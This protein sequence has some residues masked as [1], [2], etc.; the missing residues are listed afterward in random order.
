[1]AELNNDEESVSL[2]FNILYDSKHKLHHIYLSENIESD[3][4]KYF[5]L[6][7]FFNTASSTTSVE[8]HLNSGG[9]SLVVG[10]QLYWAIRT[11]KAKVH[12]IVEHDCASMGA[13]LALA[14]DTVE[15]RPGTHLMFHNYSS[16]LPRTKGKE[17][18]TTI[19]NISKSYENLLIHSCVPFLS[20]D[21]LRLILNDVDIYVYAGDDFDIRLKR[22]YRA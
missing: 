7:Y 9:G 4:S 6:F 21:E 17:L 16:E 12:V 13:V 15:M 8:I 5:D 20:W 11:S 10:S 22:Y 18:A 19:E 2:L 1:M 3:V 14:G